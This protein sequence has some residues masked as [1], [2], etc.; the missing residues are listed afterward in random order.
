[1]DGVGAE[2]GQRAGIRDNVWGGF[3]VWVRVGS[4]AGASVRIRVRDIAAFLSASAS[5]AHLTEA[6]AFG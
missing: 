6:A 2:V 1:M 5:A 4:R 3:S